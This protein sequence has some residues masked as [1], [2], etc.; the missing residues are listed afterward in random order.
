MIV[1]G[2][3]Q[4]P[5]VTPSEV[6]P[7][8]EPLD[9]ATRL[10]PWPEGKVLPPDM[11]DYALAFAN[12]LCLDPAPV[13]MGFLVASTAVTNGRLWV[14]PDP[15]NPTWR[16]PTA[17]WLATVMPAGAKKTPLLKAALAPIWAI[18][19]Q[20]RDEYEVEKAR[21][22]ADLQRWEGTKRSER[23]PKP[24]PP[25]P[26]RLL[27]HDATREALGE[28]LANNPGILAYHDELAGLFRLW[29]REDRG[30]DR[31][32]YLSAYSA[33]PIHV[34]RILRGSTF[35]AR[36]VLSLLGY[37]QPGPFRK[38]ILEAQ[39]GDGGGADGLLQRFAIVTA[40][41]R[42]WEDE[43]PPIPREY[44]ERYHN[45]VLRVYSVLH[46]GPERVLSLTPEAQEIWRK[47]ESQTERELRT[48]DHPEA[49][50][51][52]LGKRMGL[53]ARFAAVLSALWGEYTTISETTMRRA[54]ALVLWLEPHVKL[55][56]YRAIHGNDEP[57]LKL[58]RKLQ[59]GELTSFTERQLARNNVCGIATV[60]EARRV[61][62]QLLEAKWI[63]K[64]GER[65]LVNPRVREVGRV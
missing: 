7:E 29:A 25:T 53:T 30:A 1:R 12:R 43:R 32:F 47:W 63:A 22:E 58:A 42:P 21:Y 55:V 39:N 34:D 5:E 16:E 18:E 17:L 38:Y 27:V 64:D 35:I 54:I 49:W 62:A 31:A 37:I 56:W 9:S 19:A 65:Y 60:A 20:L 14:E 28:L 52:L 2:L 57:V 10:H 46:N 51:A 23:G 6:W 61:V 8:P 44:Q 13:C 36:P 24:K 48:P 59:A 33:A 41:P 26:K 45:L 15:D 40:S 50:K 3:L 4:A 11:E